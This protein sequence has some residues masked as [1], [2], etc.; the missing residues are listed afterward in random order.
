MW[1]TMLWQG[2]LWDTMV[3]KWDEVVIKK[4]RNAHRRIYTPDR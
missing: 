1:K 4:T 3:D 2:T